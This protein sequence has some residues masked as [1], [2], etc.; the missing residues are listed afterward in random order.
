[1]SGGPGDRLFSFVGEGG[2]RWQKMQSLKKHFAILAS[3]LNLLVCCLKTEVPKFNYSISRLF[4][5]FLVT[6]THPSDLF[7]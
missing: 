1:M 6:E 4:F 3:S 5:S 2:C 7:C